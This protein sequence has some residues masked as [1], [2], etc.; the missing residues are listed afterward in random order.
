MARD[1]NASQVLV[2]DLLENILSRANS[3]S[4]CGDYITAQIRELVGVRIV[5]LMQA[6]IISEGE[7]YSIVSSTPARH[8]ET[9]QYPEINELCKLSK[10][11]N[12]LIQLHPNPKGG[13]EEQIIA[14][15]GLGDSLIIPLWAGDEH[16]GALLLLDLL[17]MEGLGSVIDALNSLSGVIALIFKNSILFRNLDKLVEERTSELKQEVVMRKK[18]EE[19]IHDREAQI[20]LLLDSTAEGIYGLDLNGTCSFANAACLRMIGYSDEKEL[21]WHAH[22]HDVIHHTKPDGTDY[23]EH[24]CKI[25]K[26]LQNKEGSHVDNEILWRADGTSFPAEYWSYPII[27]D[28]VIVGA[29]VT[30]IDITERIKAEKLKNKLE[31]QLQQANKMEA[32]GTLAGGIAHDFNNIL[33]AILGYADMARDDIPESSPAKHQLE[34]V[35]KA[36]NR[37]KDLVNHILTFSRQSSG[38]RTPLQPNFIV[39]EALKLLR[40]S[41]PTTIEITENIASECGNILANSTQI[42]QVVMN[43]CTNAAQAMDEEGGALS[44]GLK[45]VELSAADLAN[46]LTSRPGPYV[47]ISVEDTG[48]GI[49]PQIIDRIFDPYFTTKAVGNGT[50]MGLAVVNGIVKNHKG[51]IRV[52]SELGKGTIFKIYFPEIKAEAKKEVTISEALT[53]GNEHILVVDDEAIL[54]N[55]TKIR[56]E[57]LGYK[58]TATT[59]STEAFEMFL[60]NPDSFDLIMTD[61]TMPQMT[62]KQLAEKIKNIRPDAKII[63]STG[64]SSKM[65]VD[66]ANLI[67]VN[68]FIMKPFDNVQLA[69]TIR[70]VLDGRKS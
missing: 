1:N 65:D 26:A 11:S 41:I 20:R 25:Y 35:L 63:I 33:A 39:K 51:I 24:E 32:I 5:A 21:L 36:S 49:N 48:T 59:S 64:Y 7:D 47:M 22:M 42:H 12:S 30:F 61:Q 4:E 16:V 15:A 28:D 60:A 70:D 13:R 27:K 53:G 10:I 37:A 38:D 31:T 62:G 58:V 23:P 14:S 50:G 29:V 57:K 56:L 43:L 55:L 54:V 67:G 68:A 44:V 8:L 3:P 9:V 45:M 2:T 18:A 19:E 66:K 46:E 17:T 40:A 69:R 34:E 6:P 52:E